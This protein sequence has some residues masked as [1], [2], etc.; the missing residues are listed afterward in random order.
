[1]QSMTGFGRSE[2]EID[3]R[4]LSIEIKSVNHRYLDINPRMP[5]YFNFLEDTLRKTIKSKISRGRIDLFINYQTSRDDAKSVEI[6]FPVIHAYI[7]AAKEINEKTGVDNDLT[8]ARLITM[9]ESLKV[10][11][12]KED[13]DALKELLVSALNEAIDNLS[14]SRAIEGANLKADISNRLV[15]INELTSKIKAKE[16][17]VV[18]E[19]KEKL[20]LRI[21]ELI[22]KTEFDENRF[23]TEVAY[24]ADKCNITEEIVRLSSHLKLFNNDLDKT[25]PCGR[26]FDF[27]VQEINREFNTIGSKSSDEQITKCVLLAKGELEKIREQIQNIE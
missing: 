14:K 4:T 12:S 11:D 15:K 18:L 10:S 24:F 21:A 8:M 26:H 20:Q 19:Y 5:R 16:N 3:G 2:I 23:N 1:M 6:N 17:D 22:D 9:P 27:L 13:E 25:E 7:N